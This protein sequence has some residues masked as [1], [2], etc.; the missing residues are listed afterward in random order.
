LEAGSQGLTV[1]TVNGGDRNGAVAFLNERRLNLWTLV[2][3]RYEMFQ[4]YGV[5]GVPTTFYID[6][7]GQIR[8]KWVGM[9]SGSIRAALSRE[10][11]DL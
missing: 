3:P 7:Q 2:D 4:Q 6:R 5:S 10:G 11:F 1:L 8:H 9:S